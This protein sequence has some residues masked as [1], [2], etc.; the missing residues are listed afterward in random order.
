M[1]RTERKRVE[2]EQRRQE[3]IEKRKNSI[4]GRIEEFKLNREGKTKKKRSAVMDR[5]RRVDRVLT[6]L[7][8]IVILLLIITWII[9]LFI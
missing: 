7:I 9:I 2:R 4:K 1:S 3:K 6:L 8:A 5:Y